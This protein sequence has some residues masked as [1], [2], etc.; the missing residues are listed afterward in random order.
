MNRI[1]REH[2]PVAELPEDLREGFGAGETVRV[3]VEVEPGEIPQKIM[4]LQELFAFAAS[5]SSE[6]TMD[7]VVAEIRQQ[8]DEWDD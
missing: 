5:F 8:R 7:D 4:S 1:V 2:Y 6:R 3:T